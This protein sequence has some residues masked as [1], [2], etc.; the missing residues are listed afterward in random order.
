MLKSSAMSASSAAKEESLK[1]AW[2]EAQPASSNQAA[3]RDA[4]SRR[5]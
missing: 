2:Q 4:T 1:M 5:R 3:G